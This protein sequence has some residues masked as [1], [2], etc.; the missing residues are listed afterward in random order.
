[1][2]LEEEEI[3]LEKQLAAVEQR[4]G[5]SSVSRLCLRFI[6]CRMIS[7]STITIPKTTTSSL[8]VIN[9]AEI[10]PLLTVAAE[11]AASND[12]QENRS[13]CVLDHLNYVAHARQWLDFNEYQRNVLRV[14]D[15]LS[16]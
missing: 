7:V 15:G 14:L 4:H 16:G 11:E 6:C 5:I 3:E 9:E 1:M 8:C 13:V 10:A 12:S 2:K